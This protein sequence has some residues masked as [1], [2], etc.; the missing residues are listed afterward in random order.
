MVTGMG[1]VSPLGNSINKFWE[2]LTN[3]RSGIIEIPRSAPTPGHSN[4]FTNELL[5]KCGSSIAGI[6]TDPLTNVDPTS[7]REMSRFL[8][9]IHHATIDCLEQAKL[10][11]PSEE[12]C[13]GTVTISLKFS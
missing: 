4:I 11:N 7:T 12:I 10:L 6:V 9:F 2:G 8:M 5:A 1:I 3:N 13:R